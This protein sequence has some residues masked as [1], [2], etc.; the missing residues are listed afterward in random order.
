VARAVIEFPGD[1]SPIMPLISKQ[2]KG[3]GFN[4]EAHLAAFNLEGNPVIIESNKITIYGIED[5]EAARNILER[6]KEILIHSTTTS[7]K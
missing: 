4:P 3:C 7:I 5:T 6:L 1:I 2:V